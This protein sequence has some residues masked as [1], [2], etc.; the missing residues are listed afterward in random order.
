INRGHG[1]GEF[2]RAAELLKERGV[3]LTVHLIFGLPGEDKA[4]MMETIRR[5]N[6][7][8]PDG[9]KIH[10]L[11]I[12]SRSA[13]YREYELGELTFPGSERHIEALAEALELLD[14]ETIVMRLTTD[15]PSPRNSVPGNFLNKTEVF[16]RT[17]EALLGR[18]SYQG[19][20]A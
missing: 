17:A 15:T 14:R 7:I 5:V 18:Q 1:E 11:H 3:K 4:M 10:N 12:P 2:F 9:I 6:R 16:R 13:L 19:K 8:K 20:K